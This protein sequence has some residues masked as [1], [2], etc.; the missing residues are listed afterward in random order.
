MRRGMQMGKKGSGGFSLNIFTDD[1][2]DEIHLATLEVLERTGVFV[3]REEARDIFDGG[4][5]I[6]DRKKKTVRIPSHIVE[7]ALRLAPSNVYLA[8]R[9]P[10]N[11][12]VMGNRR[13]GFTNF[14]AAT[15][16]VDPYNGRLRPSTNEDMANAAKLIDSLDQYDVFYRA[17]ASLD[18][19]ES[20]EQLYNAKA[21]FP[22]TTKHVFI[23]GWSTWF[24]NK[25]LKM[26]YCIVGGEKNLRDR[27][28]MTFVSCPVSPLKLVND[29]CDN[30]IGAARHHLAVCLVPMPMAGA[31]SSIKLAG[32][33]VEHNAEILSGVVLSQLTSKGAKVIYGSSNTAFDMRYGACP[34]G[35]PE[36]AKLNAATARLAQYYSLPSL[37]AGG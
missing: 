23:G 13:V 7:E 14:G 22:N 11:D 35:S 8:G 28:I 4:G 26:A 2:V 15:S 6:V 32:T 17:L 34:V 10:K 36:A 9:S 31:T 37:V 25:L 19:P 12:F 20:V 27:P 18:V 29:T 24:I 21:I 5:A 1:E 3:E 30:I 33:L 16:V